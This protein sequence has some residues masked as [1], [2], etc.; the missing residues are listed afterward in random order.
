[1]L[2]PALQSHWSMM[3]VSM[4]FFSYATLLCGSLASIAL[5]VIMSGV[6]RQVL[7][8]AMDNFFSDPFFPMKNFIH[9][10]NKKVICNTLLIFHQRIIVNVN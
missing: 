7:F 4:I 10:K 2:V 6:N 1:M 5:L 8:G 9:M 3:H